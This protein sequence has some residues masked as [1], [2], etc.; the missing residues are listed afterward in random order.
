MS[1]ELFR[2]DVLMNL[3]EA[4]PQEQM[5]PAINAVDKAA[6]NYDISRKNVSLIV[7]NGIPDQLKK[8]I[9][10]KATENIKKNTLNIY[11]YALRNFFLRMSKHIEDITATD[12][13]CYLY[14]YQQ[15]HKVS[16]R[17]LEQ[18]RIYI[19]SF[20]D[21]AV[22]NDYLT[23]NPCEKVMHIKYYAT[24]REP[25]D[26]VELETIR[27]SCRNFREKAIVDLLYSSGLRVSELCALK[28]E[29]VDFQSRTLIVRHGKGDKFRITYYN[30]EAEVSLKAYLAT[31]DD[32]CPYL[33]VN[34]RGE[35]HGIG[36]RA[37]EDTI[38]KVCERAEIDKKK[39]IPHNFRHTFATVMIDN[40]AP[41][42]HVQQLLGHAKIDTTL[43]YAKKN[44]ADIKRT[45]ERCAV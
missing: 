34:I 35:K 32:S 15:R 42:Q 27:A 22:R 10:S 6:V 41:I 24:P 1:Y 20:F 16:E 38:K 28:M 12:I 18:L 36:K 37:I 33:I 3:V 9:A 25:F 30:A 4:I 40:G 21:W 5:I 19:N 39:A 13:R 8:Y 7:V 23:K 44:M 43:I 17:T 26:A 11:F 29:D 14:E 2:N 31:R 45:H